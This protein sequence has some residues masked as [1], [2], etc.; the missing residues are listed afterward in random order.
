MEKQK[1]RKRRPFWGSI[2]TI[3]SG[4]LILWIPMN[5]FLSAFL[6]GSLA[7]IGLLFG[8]LITLIGILALFFP[9]SSKLLGVFTIFLSILSVIGA[10]GGFLI[11]TILGIIGGSLLIA[12][13]MA[14]INKK[15]KVAAE[16]SETTVQTG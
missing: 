9:N 14:P 1:W 12:W 10:L 13:R 7:V 8:G 5:L 11:G 6:P 16:F 4:L 2:V 15:E 3:L